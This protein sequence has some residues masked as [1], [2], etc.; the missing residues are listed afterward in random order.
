MGCRCASRIYSIA[1]PE[2][3]N[4]MVRLRGLR[5]SS[6]PHSFAFVEVTKHQTIQNFAIA[7]VSTG[8]CLK[9]QS[10]IKRLLMR[11]LDSYA[12]RGSV[13]RNQ[14][15]ITNP[16]YTTLLSKNDEGMPNEKR[17]TSKTAHSRWPGHLPTAL[18]KRGPFPSRDGESGFGNEIIYMTNCVIW[19][20]RPKHKKNLICRIYDEAVE[21]ELYPT[22]LLDHEWF[23]LRNRIA[24]VLVAG[25][26]PTTI[27][28]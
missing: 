18:T 4:N 10:S 3:L 24:S 11:Q 13:V 25:S 15:R 27:F 5:L 12:S 16:L 22:I 6:S 7:Y 8:V 17:G 21:R 28:W 1:L 23:R 2:C 19:A 9:N 20:P 14:Q 26:E